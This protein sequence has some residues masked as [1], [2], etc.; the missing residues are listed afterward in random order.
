MRALVAVLLLTTPAV[1]ADW[2]HFLGPTRDNFT[3]VKVAPWKGDLKPLWKVPVGEAHSSPV[4][5]DGVV[6]CFYK[7]TGLDMDALVALDADTWSEVLTWAATVASVTVS[8]PGAD[9]PYRHELR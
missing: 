4:V 3:P 5:A 9:P 1:A 6:Y 8:R 7:P 2:P